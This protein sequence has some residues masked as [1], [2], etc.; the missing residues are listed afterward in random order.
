MSR[1]AGYANEGKGKNIEARLS[2]VQEMMDQ[3]IAE[4]TAVLEQ[5]K[6]EGRLCDDHQAPHQ[7]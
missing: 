4:L 2:L 7:P 3:A 1:A 5:I 6:K